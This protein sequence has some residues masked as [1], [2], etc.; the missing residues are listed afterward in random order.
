MQPDDVSPIIWSDIAVSHAFEM[1]PGR[2]LLSEVILRSSLE[3]IADEFIGQV[4]DLA[5]SGGISVR[6]ALGRPIL[7][8]VVV[9]APHRP[10]GAEPRSAIVQA[11]CQREPL[12]EH[13]AGAFRWTR[14]V[15]DGGD[16]HHRQDY[17]N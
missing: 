16:Q 5:C 10:Q 17:S 2:R 3:T 8:L 9:I 12:G 7:A 14:R 1:D 4:A 11:I 6:E 13:D 15:I